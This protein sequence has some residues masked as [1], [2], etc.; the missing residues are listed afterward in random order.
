MSY[1][2]LTCICIR[3]QLNAGFELFGHSHSHIATL[4]LF[5]AAAGSLGGTPVAS[6][7]CACVHIQHQLIKPFCSLENVSSCKKKKREEC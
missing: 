6:R 5:A 7:L 2:H 4:L 1:T 3:G